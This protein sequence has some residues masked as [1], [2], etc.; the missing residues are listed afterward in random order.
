MKLFLSL[1]AIFGTLLSVHF[2]TDVAFK[3]SFWPNL[4]A[5]L[6][7]AIVFGLLLD[8][9]TDLTKRLRLVMVIKQGPF[10]SDVIKWT[11]A[12]DGNYETSFRIAIKNIGNK[13]MKPGE[14]YW[15]LYFPDVSEM[16]H[17][18]GAE[19]FTSPDKEHLRELINLPIFP[20]S[21]LDVG[22]EFKMKIDN[23]VKFRSYYFFSTKYG[24]FPK[25]VRMDQKTG[26]ISYNTMNSF[27]IQIV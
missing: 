22:P 7:V 17:F 1:T 9:L 14:G 3:I 11:K 13:M 6:I 20:S 19:K 2:F 8:Q 4:L 26:E 21:F 10:Y 24:Y 27:P 18:G 15:H 25:T 5:D 23:P 12:S 16:S